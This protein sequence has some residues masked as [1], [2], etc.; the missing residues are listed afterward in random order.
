MSKIRIVEDR[1]LSARGSTRATLYN[2]SNKIVSV[3][4]K[5]HVSWLDYLAWNRIQ[6]LDEASGAWG[7]VI[8]PGDGVDNHSGPALT[9]DSQGHLHIVIGA[10]GWSPFQYRKSRHPNDARL[11]L[12][13]VHVGERPTY[14]GLACD[15][16]DVL[17]L[18]YRG[19]ILLTGWPANCRPAPSLLYQRKE[20][21]A[22]N[23]MP[24]V[25]LVHP[26][27]LHGYTQYGNALC[28]DS[29]N[30]LHLCFH[31]YDDEVHQRGH[32]VGYLRSADSGRTWTRADGTPVTLPAS[33][34]TVDVVESGPTLDMRVSNVAC[35]P[36]GTPHLISFHN[37]DGIPRLWWNDGSGWKGRPLLQCVRKLMPNSHVSQDGMVTFDE[38]GN[39]Y[40]ALQI[41]PK[42]GDWGVPE[43]EVILLFSSDQGRTFE[44][45]PVSKP[46]PNTAAWMPSL[47]TKVSFHQR[48]P[49]PHMLYTVGTIGTGCESEDYTEVHFVRLGR[50]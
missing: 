21:D 32:T 43:A 28:M 36:N 48:I 41:V 44:A 26:G 40:I 47:E 30:V 25:E 23:W 34:E 14:P 50:E 13:P 37:E 31:F 10:H 20:P 45:L 49:I 19:R 33:A 7:E 8:T 12:P 29:K 46:N 1:I 38:E 4:G 42:P 5:V 15:R 11:W 35:D 17:H 27:V 3:G 39:L 9:V 2:W 16:D 18:A 24:A 6:T 22:P